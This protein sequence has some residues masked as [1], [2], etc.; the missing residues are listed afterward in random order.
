MSAKKTVL[1]VDRDRRT[2]TLL[3]TRLGERGYEVVAAESGADAFAW[4]SA[5]PADLLI[6]D[7]ALAGGSA[8]DVCRRMREEEAYRRTPI[9]LVSDQRAQDVVAG[10]RAGCDLVA[11][12]PLAPRQTVNLVEMFLSDDMPLSRRPA[13]P[14]AEACE[15]QGSASH[16]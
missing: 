1:V 5:N 15:P 11:M 3:R 6:V 4:L 16:A 12:K 10:W 7:T 13:A 14:G 9:I 8:A 2:A